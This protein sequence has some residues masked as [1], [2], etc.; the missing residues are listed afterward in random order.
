M[1]DIE[2]AAYLLKCVRIGGETPDPRSVKAVEVAR[3]YHSGEATFA[4]L[5][6]ARQ[7]AYQAASAAT[8]AHARAVVTGASPEAQRALRA[9]E[10]AVVAAAVATEVP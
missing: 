4:D 7:A 3:R 1:E 2:R 5:E 9:V 8:W 6:E 10:A